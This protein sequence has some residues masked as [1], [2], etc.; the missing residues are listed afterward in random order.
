MS[1]TYYWT[2]PRCGDNNDPGERCDCEKE[3]DSTITTLSKERSEKNGQTIAKQRQ[4]VHM[5]G[6][7]NV[8]SNNNKSGNI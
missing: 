4:F 2:C 5:F 1:D 7:Y 6:R 8:N 3:I